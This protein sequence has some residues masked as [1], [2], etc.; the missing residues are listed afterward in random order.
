L[1]VEAS[2]AATALYYKLLPSDAVAAFSVRGKVR[3]KVAVLVST[4]L[5]PGCY[6]TRI[7][8]GAAEVAQAALPANAASLNCFDICGMNCDIAWARL[9]VATSKY[10]NATYEVLTASARALKQRCWPCTQADLHIAAA[11]FQV[12]SS[13][14]YARCSL[15]ALDTALAALDTALDTGRTRHWPH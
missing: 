1:D 10:T 15:A 5:L 2:A 4:G 13:G 11:A 12:M 6:I 3:R 8:S 14:M 7:T 9:Q